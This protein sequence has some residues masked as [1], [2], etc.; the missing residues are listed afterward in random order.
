MHL[1]PMTEAHFAWLMAEA[2]PPADA[3][4]VAEGGLA[5]PDIVA[6]LRGVAAEVGGDAA[7]MMVADGE[8]VGMISI[9][10]RDAKG[11]WDIGY[12]VA[13]SREGRGHA[14]AAVSALK[15]IAHAAGAS[16]LTAET[17]PD[18]GASPRVL[19][20]NGFVCIGQFDHP[21]DGIVD[22]WV[23]EW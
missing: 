20:R 21:D 23:V 11:R 5:A 9:K 2:P 14:T 10:E 12:G 6:L 1:L 18:S 3:P 13:P 7:W 8:G 22:Q 19:R 4:P 17:L 16:G 15:E